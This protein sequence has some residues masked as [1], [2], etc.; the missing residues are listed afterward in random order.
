[1]NKIIQPFPNHGLWEYKMKSS[2]NNT[3]LRSAEGIGTMERVPRR[4]GFAIR[5]CYCLNCDFRMIHLI[6]MIICTPAQ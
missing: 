1:M 5:A 6:C 4:R 3:M 2:K